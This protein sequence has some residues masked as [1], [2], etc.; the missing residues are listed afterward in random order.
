MLVWHAGKYLY[1]YE[2]MVGGHHEA[3]HFKIVSYFDAAIFA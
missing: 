1:I 2:W 3:S